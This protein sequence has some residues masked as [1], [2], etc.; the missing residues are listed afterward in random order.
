VTK[1]T[2]KSSTVSVKSIQGPRELSQK[3]KQ[4]L[5]LKMNENVS[6]LEAQ[7]EKIPE[8]F[9]KHKTSLKR[10]HSDIEKTMDSCSTD[11]ERKRDQK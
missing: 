9:N 3:E 7:L 6:K 1:L 11:P 4:S 10:L 2:R 5:C 8:L